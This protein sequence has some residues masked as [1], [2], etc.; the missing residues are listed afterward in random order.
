MII[1]II[2]GN[3]PRPTYIW[4][5]FMCLPCIF[6]IIYDITPYCLGT[7][8]WW[9]IGSFIFFVRSFGTVCH[10]K[11]MVIWLLK[12]FPSTFQFFCNLLVL[13]V[14]LQN[15]CRFHLAILFWYTAVY[16]HCEIYVMSKKATLCFQ[17]KKIWI[18]LFSWM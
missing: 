8:I 9:L 3:L 14:C 2:Q 18:K 17:V 16:I 15:P 7:F 1:I 12:A 4:T 13:V 5:I 10:R 6:C 11:G